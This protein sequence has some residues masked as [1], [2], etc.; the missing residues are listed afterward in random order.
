[1][2]M[3]F[4]SFFIF[5]SLSS[6][7]LAVVAPPLVIDDFAYPLNDSNA[8]A[9]SIWIPT[10][11]TPTPLVEMTT[12]VSLPAEYGGDVFEKTLKFPCNFGN[13]PN[14]GRCSWDRNLSLDLSPY[15]IL[16]FDFYVPDSSPVLNLTIFFGSGPGW[17][18]VS[19][20]FSNPG[21]HRITVDRVTDFVVDNPNNPPTGWDAINRM[22]ISFWKKDNATQNT[23]LATG[24]FGAPLVSILKTNAGTTTDS[25]T[26]TLDTVLNLAGVPH[27]LLSL[28]PATL[29]EQINGSQVLLLPYNERLPEISSTLDEFVTA[30]GRLISVGCPLWQSTS[31]LPRLLG[32]QRDNRT[33]EQDLDAFTMEDTII[34]GLPNRV[35]QDWL[36]WGNNPALPNGGI[37]SARP[38]AY[39]N[40]VDPSN[41]NI[42]PT[43]PPVIAWLANSNGAHWTRLL[44]PND[45][46]AK[47]HMFAALIGSYSPA[48]A[49]RPSAVEIGRIGAVGQYTS[50]GEAV[51]GIQAT[52]GSIPDVQANL[53][54]ADGRRSQA[55]T[56]IAGED[57][58]QGLALAAEARQ[59][60]VKAHL[61]AQTTNN[62]NET[63]R[64]V[65]ASE[66]AGPFPGDWAHSADILNRSGF[67]AVYPLLATPC[68]LFYNDT[69]FPEMI[70]NDSNHPANG[71][72]QLAAVVNAAHS[73]GQE[74]HIWVTV[75]YPSGVAGA[76]LDNCKLQYGM[77]KNSALETTN[78]I[79]PCKAENRNK[80]KTIITEIASRYPVDGIHLDYIRYENSDNSY[81]EWCRER[82]TR[83]TG[84]TINNWPA[85]VLPGGPFYDSFQNWRP[86][87]ITSFVQEIN[88]ALNTDSPKNG[89]CV[90]NQ[91]RKDGLP[92]VKLS[93][94]V[95]GAN[96]HAV[97]QDWPNWIASGIVD[98][99]HPMN[100]GAS[101][102]TFDQR[103]AAQMPLAVTDSP[104]YS[105]MGQGWEIGPDGLAARILHTRQSAINPDGTTGFIQF[106]FTPEIA[107][108]F[109]PL[110]AQGITKPRFIALAASVSSS[111]A[112][113]V[114]GGK[115]TFTMDL[116]NSG[117]DPAPEV[118]ATLAL[119][120][121]VTWKA[122][123]PSQGRCY[124][125]ETGLVRC[126]LGQIPPSGSAQIQVNT[127]PNTAGTN[128]QVTS[129]VSGWGVESTPTDNSTTHT[130]AVLSS[131]LNGD[132][133][134]R[135]TVT[136]LP[137]G[138]FPGVTVELRRTDGSCGDGTTSGQDGAYFFYP[139]T[140]LETYRLTPIK[141]N[142]CFSPLYRQVTPGGAVLGLN[143]AQVACP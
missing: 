89:L 64:S 117:P 126:L 65:W 112:A 101:F 116:S 140:R 74:A 2:R 135:G 78:F 118:V 122:S 93:A 20:M 121:Q 19:R 119:P 115:L 124:G 120:S 97:G 96:Y 52:G 8:T 22:R 76:S 35:F 114:N 15:R 80:M 123:F 33:Y 45:A 14:G 85:D 92:E 28:D 4:V 12:T 46:E 105:G 86:T 30:G 73:K 138:A 106:E 113:P 5:L 139:V 10:P 31:P 136:R 1:M 25:R 125:G 29:P 104:I 49:G 68:V 47:A 6:V 34:R 127:I 82:F 95:Y 77:S 18:R 88:N 32:I 143:F 70:I 94:A 69:A 16:V 141:S 48:S 63:L 102:A 66:A 54:L 79:S 107:R 133:L 72:D 75:F 11:Y 7:A 27:R 81:D 98:R 50:Y 111:P 40:H 128:I 142:T 71:M 38:I 137:S 83:E 39:W 57:P 90:N 110:F 103:I 53:A 91:K 130:T 26:A 13:V 84:S 108:S 59:Y 60:M 51:L 58:A 99:T 55:I 62:S 37:D 134:L 67:N 100:Y 24:F 131:C 109:M 43:T 3:Y 61:Q 44:Q 23:F 129:S 41:G 87:V 56:A 42:S 36:F 21:W 17:Y 9:R 132:T